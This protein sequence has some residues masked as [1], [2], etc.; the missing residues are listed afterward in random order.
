MDRRAFIAGILVFLAVPLVAEAQQAGKKVPRI[1]VL[2]GNRRHDDRCLDAL[3]LGLRRLGY[4]EGETHVLDIR[5]A[6]LRSERFS[7]LAAELVGLHVDLIVSFTE[8]S[9]VALK[10]ATS[11]I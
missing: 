5:W 3:R 11:T 10:Q 2:S 1:G 8:G 6:E 9:L 7:Q 4:V